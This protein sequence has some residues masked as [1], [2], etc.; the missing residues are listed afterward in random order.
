MLA[1]P[2][3]ECMIAVRKLLIVVGF[4]LTVSAGSAFG[5][6]T[7][8]Y[9]TQTGGPS[10]N[11][12]TNVQTPAF[13]TNA[14]NWGTGGSQIGPGTT[15]LFCGTFTL[16]VGTSLA[17]FLGSGNAA[18]PITF[19]M[20]TNA[21]IQ[22]PAMGSASSGAF[23][24]SG[25]SY[26]IVNGGTNGIIQNTANGTGL[27]NH[28]A[29]QGLYFVNCTNVIIENITIQNI[30]A[31]LGSSSGAT[32][33]NG[34]NTDDILFDEGNSTNDQV[35]NSTLN[36]ARTGVQV[37]FDGGG[38]ASNFVISGNTINDH[39]WS[40]SMGADNAGSTAKGA[41]I[42]NNTISSWTNW[43]FPDSAY[44]TDGLIL[45]ND[46]TTGSILTFQ[47]YN[48]YFSGTLGA[49]SPTGYIAC[50]ETTSCTIF[51]NLMVDTGSNVCDGYLWMYQAGGPDYIYNNTL[52]GSSSA[53]GIAVTLNGSALTVKNNIFINVNAGLHDYSVL[54]TDVVASNN[55]I[56]MTSGGGAPSM[57]TNDSTYI[58]YANWQAD[59]FDVN[60]VTSNP[61]LAPN[62]MLNLGS[63]AKG[64]GAN[65]NGLGIPALDLDMARWSR[66]STAAWDAGAYLYN[67][68]A[69]VT[70]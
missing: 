57:A 5:S 65:L 8:I 29:S 1:R 42:Y 45:Y 69:A 62:Y 12:T 61:N 39:G 3:E 31:N 17:S 35:V 23:N 33:T 27:A 46:V 30:Y 19:Q 2:R 67:G 48:N 10:G 25:K 60:S 43:Q 63:P 13:V 68:L 4:I 49:G 54:T 44:H 9:I 50:G 41:L 6:A 36:N 47:I 55:N 32:D 64:L 11:C 14:A 22:S 52:V 21:I 70:H 34:Q 7:K 58:T 59:G 28:Q 51:N 53:G 40:V 24:C 26:V 37:D 18:N 38:D 56:W 15:V 66:S 20:D 16:S